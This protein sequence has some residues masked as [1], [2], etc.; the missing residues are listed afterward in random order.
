ML[1]RSDT[2]IVQ[3]VYAPSLVAGQQQRSGLAAGRPGILSGRLALAM[4]SG[5][6]TPI[7]LQG[8][9]MST[10]NDIWKGPFWILFILTIS[11]YLGFSRYSG[12]LRAELAAPDQPSAEPTDLTLAA[13]ATAAARQRQHAAQIA[14]LT[15]RLDAL[16][17]ERDQL[18]AQ[19][20]VATDAQAQLQALVADVSA[21]PE[22]DQ[23]QAR[24]ATLE[25]EL[26]TNAAAHAEA[27]GALEARLEAAEAAATG[28]QAELATLEAAATDQIQAFFAD[29]G[30]LK[31]RFTERG[32]LLPLAAG[33]LRFPVGAA[34]LPEELPAL[35]RIAGLLARQPELTAR[36]EGHTDS[37]GPAA[38][39]RR[40]S[41]ERADAVRAA[42]IARGIDADR[43]L[44]EG[45]GPDRPVASNDTAAGREQNRRVEI[46]LLEP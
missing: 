8:T 22:P 5:G 42:L 24:I 11:L 6:C 26:A 46:Y 25:T 33:E 32:I 37:Q 40:L 10:T 43:L 35:D 2:R 4:P 41:Q 39:N 16:G 21:A 13:P 31:A 27:M 14:E 30:D 17:A 12:Q 15:G 36:V 38:V 7:P 19:L 3:M 44:A 1:H 9:I 45:I 29:L 34:T 23:L 18:R 28:A 20:A